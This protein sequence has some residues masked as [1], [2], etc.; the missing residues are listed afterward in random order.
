MQRHLQ[1]IETRGHPRWNWVGAFL[2]GQADVG[3][4]PDSAPCGTSG[5]QLNLPEPQFISQ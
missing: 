3:L 2:W 5:N 4:N 1:G